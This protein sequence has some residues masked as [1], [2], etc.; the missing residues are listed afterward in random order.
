VA[1][2]LVTTPSGSSVF[3]G[4]LE[5]QFGFRLFDRTTRHVMLTA[6]GNQ[7][8]AINRNLQELDAA[9]SHIERNEEWGQSLSVR[10]T[11]LVEAN[12]LPQ[13]I[14]EFPSQQPDK[15]AFENVVAA[16][17]DNRVPSLLKALARPRPMLD[18]AA[19][20]EDG[21]LFIQVHS[22]KFFFSSH[23]HVR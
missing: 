1:K 16:R 18:P 4:E 13:A 7:L 15:H 20:E 22:S 14:S 6:H 2:T 11:P 19:D 8:P 23:R 10:T 17:D 21:V 5:N 12:I 3:F 9:M